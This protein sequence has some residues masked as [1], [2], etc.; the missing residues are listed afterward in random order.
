MILIGTDEGIYRWVGGSG[1]TVY[2]ALWL[3]EAQSIAGIVGLSEQLIML[4][5]HKCLQVH[6]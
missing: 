5:P 1:W 4:Q 6:A 3:P 2:H